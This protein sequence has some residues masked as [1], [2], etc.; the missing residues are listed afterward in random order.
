M[1][2]GRKE[3][4]SMQEAL[5]YRRFGLLSELHEKLPRGCLGAEC[6]M[7]QCLLKT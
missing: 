2:E 1:Q 5:Q 6:I 7:S 3:E 4:E